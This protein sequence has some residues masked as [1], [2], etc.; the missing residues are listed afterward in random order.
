[1]PEGDTILRAARTLHRALAGNP[2]TSFE[3]ALPALNRIHVYGR[4]GL[5]CR[6]CG[7]AI[8]VRKQGLDARLTYWCPACQ[9]QLL[10]P[11]QDPE[12]RT[13]SREPRTRII[14]SLT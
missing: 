1:M 5:P 14:Q 8:R 11:N 13:A 10:I 7:T 2:V 6:R 9:G 12:S 3:S 4:A